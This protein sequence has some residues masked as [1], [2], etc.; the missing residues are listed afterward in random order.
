VHEDRDLLELEAVPVRLDLAG[1]QAP[2][3]RLTVRSDGSLML[4]PILVAV[5]P[6]RAAA[7]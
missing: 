2:W 7:D 1:L 4:V 3:V 6:L 5:G